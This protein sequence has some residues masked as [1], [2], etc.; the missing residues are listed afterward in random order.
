[1]A[2]KIGPA[3]GPTDKRLHVGQVVQMSIREALAWVE[4]APKHLSKQKNEIAHAI[5]KEIRERL[6]FLNNVGS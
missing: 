2:V 6:G 1:M 4:E 3:K 5:L